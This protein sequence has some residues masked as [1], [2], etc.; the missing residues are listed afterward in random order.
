[1]AMVAMSEIENE[2]LTAKYERQLILDDSART[3][4]GDSMESN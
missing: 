2:D 3:V 4:L 1:M